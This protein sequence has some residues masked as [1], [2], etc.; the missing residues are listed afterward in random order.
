MFLTEPAFSG[1]V[2][3][4]QTFNPSI[5]T[6]P[7]LAENGIIPAGSFEGLRVFS[8][9]VAQFQTCTIQVLVVPPK[10][11][12]IFPLTASEGDAE[13]AC[14]I[15]ERTVQLLPQT[16]YQ[17]LGLNFDYFVPPPEGHD[18]LAFDRALLGDGNYPLIPEFAAADARFGRYF[19]KDHEGG[20]LKLDIK[21]VKAGPEDKDLLQ[22][23]FN[24]HYEVSRLSL[25]ERPGNLLRHIGSYPEVRRYAE[26]LVESGS[27]P[28]S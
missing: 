20:G 9:Q 2:L 25:S 14:K 6:E 12:I 18:F 17:A 27:R 1:I 19:S 5:F 26:H 22:F 16:P 10:M 23:S 3:T 28:A 8:P 11:Q 21:P 7:W 13:L 24:F 4:A 15:A